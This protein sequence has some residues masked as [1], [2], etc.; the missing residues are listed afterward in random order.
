MNVRMDVT[1]ELAL[2]SQ[3]RMRKQ[4]RTQWAARLHGST[5]HGEED[6]PEAAGQGLARGDLRASWAQD[7]RAS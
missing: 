7:G 1:Y 3:A 2:E 4:A 5:S 6:G